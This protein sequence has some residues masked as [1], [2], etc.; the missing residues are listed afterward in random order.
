MTPN[1]EKLRQ[2]VERLARA[3]E[4]A[5]AGVWDWDI[6]TNQIDWSPELFRLFG[7]N[8]DGA[9]ASFDTWRKVVH[10]D[11]Q[12][13]AEERIMVAI[14]NRVPLR[15]EYRIVLPNGHLRWIQALGNTRYDESGSPQNM[16][17]IC[18]DVTERRRAERSLRLLQEERELIL[19]SVPAMIWYKD[20]ENRILRVNAAAARSLGLTKEQIE[21]RSTSE[22]YPEEAERYFRDDLAVVQ[23]GVPRFGIEEPYRLP[24][25][26][27]RW[28]RTDKVPL[29]DDS[30]S[31]T[32]LLVM[33]LDIT[34][35]KQLEEESARHLEQLREAD[36]RKDEFLAMLGHE[37]RNPLSPLRNAAE[38]LKSRHIEPATLRWCGEMI[39]RQV[40]Y[41]TRLVDDLL[42]VARVAQ[43]RITLQIR[44]LDLNEVVR[45][46]VESIQPLVTA[47]HHAVSLQTS[48]EPL[49]VEGDSVRLTQ[50][51]TNL[52]SNAA[53]YSDEGGRI[54]VIVRSRGDQ[55]E[56]R[57]RDS[58]RG[59]D[60][61]K[62]A[63]V[64]DMFYQASPTLDRQ[65]GGLGI[66]LFLVR[67]LVAMHGGTVHAYSDGLGRGSEF[68][69]CL[70]C[71]PRDPDSGVTIVSQPQ[72]T[73]GKRILVVDDNPDAAQSLAYLLRGLGH[74][75]SVTDDGLK[76]L[77]LARQNR[78]DIV[79]LD[80]GLP[81]MD[82]FGVAQALRQDP[83]LGVFRV[84]AVTGYGQDSARSRAMDA[85]FD[86]YLTKPVTLSDLLESL[87]SDE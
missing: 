11:D 22:F 85:G 45:A 2:T 53:N 77:E 17:G 23:T 73:R 18:L 26:E 82:G 28:V 68:L 49:E 9:D 1:D 79:I 47:R 21:G 83:T 54:E 65:Q 61:E 36:R 30:G 62:L 42:D 8:P 57:V 74:E 75:V 51:V 55:A 37:L 19:D 67:S 7:L 13:Q 12:A 72:T 5:G 66:G 76:A 71:R 40:S 4:T 34:E 44:P 70:P 60:P 63:S 81:G 10:P 41:L 24:S 64:F 35:R 43:G 58:G 52:L 50:V 46:A 32:R 78:P 15:S 25:G 27:V 31:V 84:I 20:T 29:K 38:I 87:G 80:I 56:I 59:I 16:A 14:R 39:D 33:S 48:T 6:Q 86:D 69:V 3:Q